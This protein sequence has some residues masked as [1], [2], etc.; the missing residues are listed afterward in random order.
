MRSCE[1]IEWLVMG[2]S[3]SAGGAPSLYFFFYF[4]AAF[5]LLCVVISFLSL[6]TSWLAYASSNKKKQQL[7]KKWDYSVPTSTLPSVPSLRR[8]FFTLSP[9]MFIGFL[10]PGKEN[11]LAAE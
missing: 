4:G 2:S 8:L 6:R 5:H 11:N 10:R 7:K 3:A 1:P 9:S